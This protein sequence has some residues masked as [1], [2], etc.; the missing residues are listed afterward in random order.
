M[1]HIVATL[2]EPQRAALAAAY[3]QAVA[4]RRR[5][6]LIGFG[7]FLVALSISVVGAEVDPVMFWN[8]LGN[9]SSYFDRLLTLDAGGRVWTNPSDWFWGIHR[10]LRLLG[11]TVLIAYVGTLTGS[12]IA[13]CACFLASRNLVR[14]ATLR[15][16]VR[17][18]LELLRTVP[19]LVF[20]M[21]FV[22][23][24]GLGPLPGV[25]AL[26]LHSAGTL[27]K[28]FTEMVE[29]IDL[30][31][32]EGIRAS[33]GSWL[34]QVRFGALPQVLSNF[35]SYALLRLEINVRGAAVIGFVGAGGIGEDLLI[36]I[37]KF[38]YQDVSA[39]LV[40]IVI[41]VMLLDMISEQLRHRLLSMGGR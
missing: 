11:E 10:W 30:R 3:D 2:P 23:A 17:R 5:Q 9:F 4:A 7:V 16:V 27:G 14:S 36:A 25:L 35:A 38:Y 19:D 40:L 15:L 22:V 39:M 33:G 6:L 26:A 24:F 29:S 41:C 12:F 37:R 20:A 13:F 32:I 31:P 21:L 18:V 28:L 8:K 1:A 34:S